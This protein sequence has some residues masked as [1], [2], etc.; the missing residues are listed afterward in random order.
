MP[1]T[2]RKSG[3]TWSTFIKNH[4]TDIRACDFT[5]VHD[6]LF[7][8]IYIFIIMQMK[9]RRIV[10]TAVKA[11]PTDAWTAQHLREATPWGMKPRF[12]IRDNDKKYGRLFS[13]IARSSGIREI[14]TPIQAPKA[15]AICERTIGRLKRECLDHMLIIHR[16]RL[17]RIL[18]EYTAY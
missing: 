4:S 18:N 17:K 12:L 1:K 9:P 3:Q 15:N 13:A 2:R 5:V 10:H 7:R 8:P 14:R 6:L 11:S 16:Y